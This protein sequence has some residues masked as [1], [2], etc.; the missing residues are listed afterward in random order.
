[1]KILLLLLVFFP[2]IAQ[3]G[4][5]EEDRLRQR[6]DELEKNVQTLQDKVQKMESTLMKGGGFM[7][8]ANYTCELN[9]PFDGEY[10]ATELSEKAA[11]TSVMEKC[12]SKARD[13]G[14]CL[15][16]LIKCNK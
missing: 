3:A 4:Q 13:K 16:L 15:P 9:T 14:Q 11:K 12:Q 7:I 6:V 2:L 8:T 1:M 10:T 5:S